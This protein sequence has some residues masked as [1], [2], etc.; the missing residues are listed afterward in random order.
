MSSKDAALVAD[1]TTPL[2][3]RPS[4]NSPLPPPSYQYD[5]MLNT[6]TVEDKETIREMVA[7]DLVARAREDIERREGYRHVADT[8][9]TLGK[10][11]AGITSILAFS[12]TAFPEQNKILSFSAGIVGTIGV[13]L[14]GWSQYAAKES[15][16]R[17]TRLNSIL[18]GIGLSPVPADPDS[19]NEVSGTTTT[20]SREVPTTTVI[21][22]PPDSTQPIV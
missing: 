10:F 9:E 2:L 15:A 13:A 3:S 16:E 1:A 8:T 22:D 21:N 12:A 17:L 14:S 11:L 4:V 5:A 19:T 7:K 6:L 20:Q 18:K